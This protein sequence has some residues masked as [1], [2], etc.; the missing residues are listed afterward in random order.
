MKLRAPM[1]ELT[2]ATEWLNGEVTKEQLIGEKPTLIHFWS[3]SCHL[4]KEA[5]PQVNEF[6]DEYKD[7]LNVIAVHMPRSED[8]LDL[9]QIKK[10]AAEHDITQPIYVD[11]EHKLNEAF[12]NQ[13]VPAY[14]V[15]DK[16]GVLRHFQAGGSG[17]KMLTKR[18]NRVLD[19]MNK[20]E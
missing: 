10:V 11:S 14:Y 6:R 18:V 5:M 15:F 13:Y 4:C 9:D 12:E 8:D 19:E 2:G 7:Q 1:P 17:M 16:D 3:V 20:A